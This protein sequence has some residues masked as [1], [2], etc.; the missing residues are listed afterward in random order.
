M[1]YNPQDMVCWN[2]RG[3]NSPARKKALR[4]FVESVRVAIICIIETKLESVDQFVIM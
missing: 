2:V 1:S 4:E 3:L